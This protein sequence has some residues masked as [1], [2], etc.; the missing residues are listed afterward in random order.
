MEGSVEIFFG[1][2]A[3]VSIVAGIIIGL[4]RSITL[5]PAGIKTIVLVSLGSSMFTS[6][7]FYLY[8]IYPSSDPNRIIGQ[9]ITGIGF[10]CAGVIFRESGKIGGLTSSAMIWTSA[11]LGTIAGSGLILVPIFGS[12][13]IVSITTITRKIENF[14][15]DKNL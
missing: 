4:E 2:R 11:A 5:H 12:L 9:I 3:L 7:A 1:T 6:L 15:R 10:L 14:I 8:E 13:T